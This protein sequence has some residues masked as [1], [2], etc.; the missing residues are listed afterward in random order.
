MEAFSVDGMLD[1]FPG[2]DDILFKNDLPQHCGFAKE[3]PPMM[4]FCIGPMDE[5]SD[6]HVMQYSTTDVP[7]TEMILLGS[8]HASVES[9]HMSSEAG[10]EAVSRCPTSKADIPKKASRERRHGAADKASR[11]S[12][13]HKQIIQ[14]QQQEAPPVVQRQEEE[15]DSD[16]A[17][18]LAIVPKMEQVE[19]TSLHDHNS[20]KHLFIFQVTMY[21]CPE[22]LLIG[23]LDAASAS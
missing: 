1:S 20:S 13:P 4:E 3:E 22:V 15:V 7:L 2:F 12:S 5:S 18:F 11:R 21:S 10:L 8:P 6:T 17:D 16:F 19:H 9:K 14:Q 23:G